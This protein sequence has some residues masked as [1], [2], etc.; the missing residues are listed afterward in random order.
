[1]Q[2]LEHSDGKEENMDQKTTVAMVQS[3]HGCL[4]VRVCR[5]AYVAAQQNVKFVSDERGTG[6]FRTRF[7]NASECTYNRC[8]KNEKKEWL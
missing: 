7:S 6:R 2:N 4:V 5:E 3:Q 1:M 8:K